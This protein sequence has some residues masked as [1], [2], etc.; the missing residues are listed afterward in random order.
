VKRTLSRRAL[1]VSAVVI[2]LVM[3]GMTTG[4][5]AGAAKPATHTVTIENTAFSPAEL[6][7]KASDTIVWINKDPYPHSATSEAGGFD[8]RPIAPGESWKFVAHKTGDFPY[9]CSIHP[10]MKATLH[11]K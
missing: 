7:I 11:V 2:G 1:A 3:L 6:D 5:A 4:S 10:S 9:T 8:S